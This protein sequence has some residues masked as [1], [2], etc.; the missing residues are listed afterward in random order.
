MQAHQLCSQSADRRGRALFAGKLHS[1]VEVLEQRADMPLHGLE[2]ALGHLRGE[3]LQGSGIGETSDQGFGDQTCIDPG[4]LG[5]CHHFGDHQRVAGD[6]HLVAGLG[7]LPGA[8][9][10]H[11]RHPLTEVQQD[12]LDPLKV[13]CR[14]A[15]HNR[16]AARLGTDH[17]AG[18]RCIQPIHAALGGK[19]RGHFPRRGGLQTG[20]IHQRLTTFRPTG[21]A[22]GAENHLAHH[23][24][25]RQAQH[26]HIGV[27]AQLGRCRHLPGASLDQGRALGRIA[28]PHRQRIPRS[29]QTPA[30]G[31]SHQADSGEPQRR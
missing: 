13:R 2:T 29:Q 8:D 5:Q 22:G 1:G 16:Q 9:A 19:C 27:L 14:A 6:D 28:I 3:D 10:A 11:V 7:H 17:A 4:T 20:K 15:H 26:H 18:H 30:H 23:R 31:Q 25:V 21:D 12:R 24:R